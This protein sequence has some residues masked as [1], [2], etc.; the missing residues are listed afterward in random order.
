MDPT[1]LLQLLQNLISNALKYRVRTLESTCP[2]TG[3][4]IG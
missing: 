3:G 4:P 2:R 1:Q